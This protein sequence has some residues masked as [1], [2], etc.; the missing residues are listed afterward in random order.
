[1][2][3]QKKKKFFE[4]LSHPIKHVLNRKNKPLLHTVEWIFVLFSFFIIGFSVI[5]YQSSSTFFDKF[6]D[7]FLESKEA[8]IQTP[9]EEKMF[10][11]E[12]VSE[13]IDMT[14]W[15]TYQN[16]WYGFEIQHPDSWTNLQFKSAAEK[17]ARY[18]TIYKFRRE[19]EEENSNF[20]G[21]D[22]AVYPTRKAL[23]L[24]NTNDIDKK[25]NAPEDMNGC[26]LSE[27][28]N[29]GSEG[30]SFQKVNIKNDNPCFKPAYF[31]S[32]ARDGYIYN[33]VPALKENAEDFSDPEKETSKLF[34]EYKEAVA[35]FK[36]I[37]L[38]RPQPELQPKPKPDPRAKVHRPLQ[39]KVVGGNLVCILKNEHP[40]KSRHG[41]GRHMDEDCCMDPDETPNPWCS[42]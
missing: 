17:N 20:I 14:D 34:P 4:K 42:Y 21:F 19:S 28:A 16:K 29:L 25:E 12:V 8:L 23:K 38:T 37:K 2:K 33:I 22:V 41:K 7:K 10:T 40:H 35:T 36:F 3:K 18:E 11:G 15:D 32:V 27:E 24:E 39:A 5:N 26:P 30:L 6:S 9:E 31:Y 1:M 13:P